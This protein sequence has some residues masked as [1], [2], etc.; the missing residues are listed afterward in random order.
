MTTYAVN[1]KTKEH[2]IAKPGEAWR[3]PWQLLSA[4]EDGWVEWFGG[5]CPLPD[6]VPFEAKRRDGEVAARVDSWL[7]GYGW[8]DITAYRPILDADTKP[9]APAWD[10]DCPPPVGCVCEGHVQDTARQWRWVAVEVL[11][12]KEN[13]C[14][15]HVPSM[16]VLRWCDEFRPIRSQ[17]DRAVEEMAEAIEDCG[18]ISMR[19]STAMEVARAI[20][21]AGYRKEEA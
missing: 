9:E 15:V 19:Q 13:E 3:H 8:R 17:E 5:E 18:A 4:D 11:M 2:R 12:Q 7:H 10:G 20:Y 6:G 1:R 16:G 14:A 21:R